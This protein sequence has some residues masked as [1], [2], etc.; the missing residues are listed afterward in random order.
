M[1]ITRMIVH[2]FKKNTRKN[3]IAVKN[4]AIGQRTKRTTSIVSYVPLRL[5]CSIRSKNLLQR[6]HNIGICSSSN[7]VIDLL[8]GWQAL[9]CEHTETITRNTTNYEK[10]FSLCLQRIISTKIA[11]Q[12]KQRNISMEQA[13]APSSL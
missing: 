8:S 1:A 4:P 5:Y 9:F 13:S 6:L 2:N 10:E 12:I 3:E 7:H 11:R